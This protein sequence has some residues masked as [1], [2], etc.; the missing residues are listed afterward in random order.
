[1][2]DFASKVLHGPMDIEEIQEST[3]IIS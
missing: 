1:M 2:L 3:K